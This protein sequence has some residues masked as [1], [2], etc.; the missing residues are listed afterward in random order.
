MKKPL[1]NIRILDM[2]QFLSASYCTMLLGAMGAEIIKLE[3]PGVGDSA[4]V[5]PPFGG[6]KGVSGKVQTPEDLS[7]A[8]LKRGRNKKSITQHPFA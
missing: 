2:S 8:I 1:E 5:S 7:L 6:P 4:R 3:R